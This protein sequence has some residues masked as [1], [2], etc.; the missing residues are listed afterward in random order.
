MCRKND[1][2]TI[3]L[4]Q[5]SGLLIDNVFAGLRQQIG[6]KTILSRAGFS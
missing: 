2:T 5:A 6:M 3:D 1:R 4:L